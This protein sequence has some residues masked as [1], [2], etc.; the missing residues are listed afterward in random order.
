MTAAY[1]TFDVL[2][3]FGAGD[4]SIADDVLALRSPLFASWGNTNCEPSTRVAFP[5]NFNFI[6]NNSEYNSATLQGYYSPGHGSVRTGFG[7]ETPVTLKISYG[8]VNKYKRFYISAIDPTPGIH[9]ERQTEIQA[10]DFMGRLSNQN[11]AG[12][13]VQV[14]KRI[15][16]ALTTLVALMP[17]APMATA[18]SVAPETLDFLFTDISDDTSFLTAI[19]HLAMTDA[20]YIGARGDNADGEEFFYET[21]QERQLKASGLTLNGDMKDLSMPI[22]ERQIINDVTAPITPGAVGTVDEIMYQ[23]T[24]EIQLAAGATKTFQ[25][26]YSEP[27][28]GSVGS[29]TS[30]VLQPGTGVAPVAGTDYKASKVSGSLSGDANASLSITVTW[31]AG[32]AKVV[33]TNLSATFDVFVMPFKLRGR[34]IRIYNAVSFRVEDTAANYQKYGRRPLSYPM[35]YQSNINFANDMANHWFNMWHL[36]TAIPQ[37]IEFSANHNATFAAAAVALDIGGRFTAVEP[38]TGV[39]TDFCIMGIDLSIIERTQ[40]IM[41]YYVEPV[42]L[43]PMLILDDA[44]YGVLDSN[45]A[46]VGF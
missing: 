12:L 5:G 27:G 24:Q 19:Q 14:S 34:I 8:G 37:W 9:A 7:L 28:A 30:V 39:S 22:N 45:E 25:A 33:F 15:D 11:I 44:I 3:D 46:R 41:R 31:Y 43:T 36:P 40:L 2:M 35:Y 16:Q 26:N 13:S 18:Y 1:P 6:L 10:T 21:R 42:N 4:V 29:Y 32:Y 17:T 23:I 20:G 38:V